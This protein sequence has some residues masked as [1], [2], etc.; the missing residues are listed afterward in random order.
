M[1]RL[2]QKK[3]ILG[4]L[5]FVLLTPVLLYYTLHTKDDFDTRS[6]AGG[7]VFNYDP[8]CLILAT[9]GQCAVLKSADINQD[10]IINLN[11]DYLKWLEGYRARINKGIYVSESDINRDKVVNLKDFDIWYSQYRQYRKLADSWDT[12]SITGK[13]AGKKV[14]KYLGNNIWGYEILAWVPGG[15]AYFGYNVGIDSSKYPQ[16]NM[17]S[18]I[19]YQAKTPIGGQMPREVYRQIG[20]FV[21]PENARIV[22]NIKELGR[23]Y[24]ESEQVLKAHNNQNITQKTNIISVQHLGSYMHN[25]KSWSLK[26][27]K[28]VSEEEC[29]KIGINVKLGT[30]TN[31][32]PTATISA[33]TAGSKDDNAIKYSTVQKC[34]ST[35]NKDQVCIGDTAMSEMHLSNQ[36]Y[37]DG[38]C[39]INR[40]FEA[41]WNTAILFNKNLP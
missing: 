39:T 2:K 4:L 5:S 25:A 8:K 34:S 12:T 29:N 14:A 28:K 7:V 30:N 16:I 36:T 22:T 9:S 35:Q 1:L 15:E 11:S 6:K 19:S 21:A 20:K 40:L 38:V 37:K 17:S 31:N 13:E 27:V 32:K 23:T 24:A 33:V 18:Y 26:L 41:D 10:G 3:T